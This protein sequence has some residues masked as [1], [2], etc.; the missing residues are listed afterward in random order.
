MNLKK[1]QLTGYE[2]YTKDK[3]KLS[4]GISEWNN[5]AKE[6]KADPNHFMRDKIE[7]VE[8]IMETVD[9]W[10]EYHGEKIAKPRPENW[11]YRK[12]PVCCWTNEAEEVVKTYRKDIEDKK[13]NIQTIN[14]PYHWQFNELTQK[15]EI[16]D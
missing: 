3:K 7:T 2:I 13:G 4:I 9:D 11:Q 10:Y 14:R 8:E 15:F 1:L 5:L 6:I 16:T 12:V